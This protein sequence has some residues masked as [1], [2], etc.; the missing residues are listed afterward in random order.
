MAFNP[1]RQALKNSFPLFLIGRITSVYGE[2]D[3]ESGFSDKLSST[4]RSTP[5]SLPE[6]CQQRLAVGVAQ[7]MEYVEQHE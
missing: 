3:D 2:A 4:D 5:A 6:I 1:D 7:A